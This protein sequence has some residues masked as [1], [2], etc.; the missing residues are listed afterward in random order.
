MKYIGYLLKSIAIVIRMISVLLQLLHPLISILFIPLWVKKVPLWNITRCF[1]I[2]S[3]HPGLPLEIYLIP[4]INC[5]SYCGVWPI[6]CRQVSKT[7]KSNC[8]FRILE[9]VDIGVVYNPSQDLFG[10]RPQYYYRTNF[11][12][13]LSWFPAGCA[14]LRNH[15]FS[16]FLLSLE[17]YLPSKYPRST[18]F[19][20]SLD[21]KS[22]QA[23]QPVL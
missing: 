9:E 22:I 10:H 18:P 2:F 1:D 3:H 6:Q 7:N 14:I 13:E 4:N 16:T 23:S 5:H 20:L 15:L 21:P 8:R 12:I 17:V 19:S 11:E